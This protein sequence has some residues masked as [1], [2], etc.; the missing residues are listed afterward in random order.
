MTI[1]LLTGDAAVNAA[2]DS[3][4]SGTFNPR[5]LRV[6]ESLAERAT[7]MLG[8]AFA[9][10]WGADVRLAEAFSTSDFKLAAS[11]ELDKEMLT[12]YDELPSTWDQ[13]SDTTTVRDFRPKRLQ[14][15]W[16]ST[17][18]MSR[19]PEL[20]E[21]PAD[22]RRGATEYAIQVAKYGR[23]FAISWE[24]W[25]NNEAIGEIEDLPGELA[26][27]ARET[28]MIAAVSNLLLVDPATNTA[29]D[30][31]TGFFKAGN[32]NTPTALPLNRANLKSVWDGMATKKDPN[33]KRVIARPDMT[34]VIPKSLEATVLSIVRPTVVRT[35]VN[36]VEV[37]ETNEFSSLSYVVEPM[38]DFVNAHANAATTWFLVPKPRSTR[39]ALWVAKLAGHE[40]P[41][42]RVRADTGQRV[43]GGDISALEGSFEI[44]DIQY[45]GRHI[46]GNQQ[47]DPLFTYVSRG[48]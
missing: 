26:R 45:R 30:V 8:E 44:D 13:Y 34:L 19:V 46:V 7:T 29:T 42:L 35:T 12:Q 14:S 27:Q 33:S 39:P 18:G 21:Y 6:G 32:G 24:A 31:N 38:L 5:A 4:F 15:R 9:N 43:G 16:R 17:I 2:S 28:E 40:Q 22:D 25:M 10:K 3:D 1:E 48:A 20:T 41:D 11:V 36:G 47:G 37:E 23:R